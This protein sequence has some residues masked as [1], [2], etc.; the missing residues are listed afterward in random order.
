MKTRHISI[1]ILVGIL[2]A[3]GIL[4][5][6]DPRSSFDTQMGHV[7]ATLNREAQVDASGPALLAELIQR[8]YGTPE[9]ELQWAVRQSVSWG[10]IAALAYIRRTTGH[11]F[12][13]IVEE[14]ARLDFW[15]YAEKA[16]MRSERMA[17]SLNGFLKVAEK[18]RNSRIFE[19]L[20]AS[21]RVQAMPDLGSGFGL[22]QEALDFRRIDSPRPTKVHTVVNGKAKVDQ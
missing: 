4:G 8:E 20:R 5:A 9:A 7:I 17:H 14:N 6:A 11:S 2:C 22:F 1:G 13:A 19:R 12:E 15:A 10:E 21:R 16:D 3:S 18:E